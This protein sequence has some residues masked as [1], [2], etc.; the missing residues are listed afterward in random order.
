MWANKACQVHLDETEAKTR[1]QAPVSVPF[2]LLTSLLLL[3]R[4]LVC[5]NYIL[6]RD[7]SFQSYDIRNRSPLRVSLRSGCR[8]DDIP[9]CRC[10]I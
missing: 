5:L 10:T 2:E 9:A 3:S 1:P 7:I 4:F 8:L 6:P